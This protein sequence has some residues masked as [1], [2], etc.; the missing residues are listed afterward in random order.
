M[1]NGVSAPEA[2]EI[3]RISQRHGV[4]RLRVFGSRATGRAGPGSDLDLLA[5][6]ESGRDLLDLTG[7]K[8]EIEAV[9][10]CRVDVVTEA[11]LS[12][13]LRERVLRE[14]VPL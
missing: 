5:D 8:Q 12:P 13:Y 4:R 7:F 11:S 2:D 1:A 6:F 9:L 14:A 10:G 3:R